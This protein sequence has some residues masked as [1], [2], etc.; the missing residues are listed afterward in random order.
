MVFL[1]YNKRLFKRISFWLLLCAV[2]LLA[3][4]MR[5]LSFGESGMLHILLCEEDPADVLSGEVTGRLLTEKSVIQYTLVQQPEEARSLVESGRADAAWIFP[6]RMQERLDR[7]TDGNFQ[8][9]GLIRVIEREDNVA[10]RLAR[11]KLFGA[12]YPHASYSLYRNF[13]LKDLGLT[14]S[15]DMLYRIHENTAVEGSLF[16]FSVAGGDSEASNAMQQDFLVT[17]VRGMLALLLL[18]CGLAADMYYLRDQEKGALEAVSLQRR[19]RY[20][21]LHQL[22]VT[23]AVAVVSLAALRCSGIFTIWHREILWMTVY[24][25][26]CMGFCSLLQRLCGSLHRL[27]ALIPVLMLISF[28]LCPVFFSM[29]QMKA[30]QY[31]LP[32][33]YY[34]NAIHNSNYLYGMFFYCFLTWGIDL[35]WNRLKA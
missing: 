29:R 7:F 2:P 33:Y 12:L 35:A 5:Y 34:L 1:L 17:P 10:L 24:I 18:L 16:R 6:D 22:T 13:L 4:A 19:R 32:P 28:V 8:E 31:L 3:L 20:L 15:E 23:G 14:A 9:E 27:A 25:A 30:L 11:E 21:Y 26:M